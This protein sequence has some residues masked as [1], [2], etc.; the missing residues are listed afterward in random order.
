GRLEFANHGTLFL[1]DID[2]LPRALQPVLLRAIQEGQF[3]RIGGREV[4]RVDVRLIAATTQSLASTASLDRFSED[5]HGLRVVDL[6]IPPRPVRRADLP[7]LASSVLSRFIEQYPRPAKL[8]AEIL[9]LFSEY[10]WPSN[11]RELEELVRRLVVTDDP[12]AIQEEIRF[13]LRLARPD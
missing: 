4:I 8:S 1:D 6:Q 9:A 12:R 7:A 11:I 3:W 5:S 10:S 2:Q 13:Q